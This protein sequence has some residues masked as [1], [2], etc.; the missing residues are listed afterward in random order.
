MFPPGVP[1]VFAFHGYPSLVHQLL[2]GRRAPDRFHVHG[3]RERGTTTTPFDMLMLNDLD[4]YTLATDVIARALGDAVDTDL[5]TRWRL[6]REQARSHAYERGTDAP[7][8]EHWAFRE[9][10]S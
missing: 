5:V 7:G 8:I 10:A 9:E 2:H 6:A 1:V 4:R 3:F